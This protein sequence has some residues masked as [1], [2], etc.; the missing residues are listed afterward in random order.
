M[1][2]NLKIRRLNHNLSFKKHVQKSA[3]TKLAQS[4]PDELAVQFA[5]LHA[6]TEHIKTLFNP[7]LLVDLVH[8]DRVTRALELEN[9]VAGYTPYELT[10]VK[11]NMR[12]EQDEF[13][14]LL[15]PKQPEVIAIEDDD[16][17]STQAS[18]IDLTDD[19]DDELPT[20]EQALKAPL[21]YRDSFGEELDMRYWRVA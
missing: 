19:D 4:N 8:S 5:L 11:A 16:D 1:A 15:E 10:M 21:I 14:Q 7:A 6:A 18:P 3:L 12:A 9:K 20:V 13:L 17:T 2:S